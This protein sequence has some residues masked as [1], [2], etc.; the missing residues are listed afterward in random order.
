MNTN[1]IISY[2][3][4]LSPNMKQ[5]KDMLKKAFERFPSVNG[6]I[7]HS[8]QGWQYQHAAYRNELQRHGVVQSMSRKGN[9]YELH[10]GDFLWQAKK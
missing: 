10:P 6:L 2:N 9:C 1:E 3:L 4:S 5:I 8:D 7:M